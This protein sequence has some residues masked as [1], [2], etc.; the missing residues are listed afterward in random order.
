MLQALN[1]CEREKHHSLFVYNADWQ[2]NMND[3][4][5]I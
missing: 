4:F 5:F 1:E 2:R 3:I